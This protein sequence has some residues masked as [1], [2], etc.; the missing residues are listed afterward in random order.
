[1]DGSPFVDASICCGERSCRRPAL[2]IETGERARRHMLAHYAD[3]VLGARYRDRLREIQR[4]R[5]IGWWRC[6]LG[7]R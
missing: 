1:V 6:R 3:A 5:R 4:T 2:G 7:F